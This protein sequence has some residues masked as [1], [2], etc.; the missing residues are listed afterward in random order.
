M[1]EAPST[2]S[3]Q[4]PAPSSPAGGTPQG[5]AGD[6]PEGLAAKP[7]LTAAQ[8]KRANQSLKGM[9][10]SVVLTLLVVLPVIAMNPA[11]REGTYQRD[12]NVSEVAAQAAQAADFTP[13]A[14]VMA[15]GWYANF[16]RW[17]GAGA[18]GVA[19][20]EV[21]FVTAREGFI[22]MRQTADANPSWIAQ[23]TDF[24][25]ATGVRTVD[26]TDWELRDK[27]GNRTLLL[28]RG[29]VTVMLTGE[30]SFED[31]DEAARAVMKALPSGGGR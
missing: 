1:S 27:A 28:E 16:A 23:Q 8:A 9:I 6:L 7:V 10:I 22:W 29:G 15:E 11:N 2:P 24:A 19:F 14:P 17:T 30:S 31:L 18:D 26:G 4:S 13:V 25:P 20:W 21:G 5:A 12:I 3:Q